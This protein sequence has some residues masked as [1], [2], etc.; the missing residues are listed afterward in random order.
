M[1][2][3]PEVEHVRMSLQQIISKKVK[4]IKLTKQSQK[5]SKY[6]NKQREFDIFQNRKIERIERKGK[7]LVWV[8][9][10]SEIILNHLGMSGKWLFI[11]DENL[12]SSK[13]AKIILDIE[14][15]TRKVVF[16][17]VRNF[18]QFRI[19]DSYDSV[20]DY[21]PI[22]SIGLDGLELPF[23]Q[24]IFLQKLDKQIYANREIGSVLLNQKMVAGIGNIYKSESLYAARIKPT[25][26]VKDISIKERKKLGNE[27]SNILHKALVHQGSSFNIQP[28]HDPNGIEG[29]AQNW[30]N[31]Y[32]KETQ[33]CQECASEIQK[34]K[35]N[36]RSTFFCS[37]CQK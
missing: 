5:Y 6:K 21:N 1:P 4:S 11:T 17:D 14:S 33:L 2:E 9:D 29:S 25:R 37:K 3:G 36:G 15:F 23:P 13:H 19:F 31:V 28:F 7:F 34:I 10:I 16:D 26:L 8:F 30:H 24:E 12:R 18:G 22:K 35:Q 27:I 20:M 32:A